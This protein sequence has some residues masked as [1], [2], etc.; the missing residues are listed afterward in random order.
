MNET[1][2][3]RIRLTL[4]LLP[5]IALIHLLIFLLI[6]SGGKDDNAGGGQTAKTVPAQNSRGEA[7]PPPA[8]PS[9]KYYRKS[10]NP[11]FGKDFD[12]SNALTGDLA[13]LPLC[14]AGRSGILVDLDTRKVLWAKE[15]QKK[16]AIASL[17]KM[18]TVL[19]AFEELE[20]RP[21]LGLNTQVVVSKGC[22]QVPR[23][24]VLG[25]KKGERT[26]LGELIM[27]SA[28][29]SA[30]DSAYMLGE[31]FGGGSVE[32]FV[33][34]MNKRAGELGMKNTT[35]RN[36]HGLPS[37]GGRPDTV[38]SA[39]DMIILGERLLEY[40]DY[41]KYS[42][43]QQGAANGGKIKFVNTNTLVRKKC[44]GV[45]GLKT[46]FTNKAG[47]CIVV[48]CLRNGKRLMLCLMGFPSGSKSRDI[49]AEQL[50]NFGYARAQELAAG[51]T[52]AP[53]KLRQRQ[54]AKLINLPN[55]Q[56]KS[57]AA[58][59]PQSG[60]TAKKKAKKNAKKR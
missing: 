10:E 56:G 14:K 18:M 7:A 22:T 33:E 42:S 5:V 12:Y 19:L 48:S 37:G 27:T 36:M 8:L 46:G 21:E 60:V 41:L 44:A 29:K 43:M 24:G 9:T 32:A 38:S 34:R 23:T 53:D 30:N 20:R 40:P 1:N 13:G 58:G 51:I 50:L 52:K 3:A 15:P 17:T 39:E 59:K 25:W 45:D 49:L 57:R 47:F 31:Y 4:I 28:V 26:T 55:G 16:A 11:N 35:F 54:M 6:A 2:R